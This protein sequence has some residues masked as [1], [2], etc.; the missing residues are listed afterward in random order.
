MMRDS[1]IL[2]ALGGQHCFY[3]RLEGDVRV[4]WCVSL[5]SYCAAIISQPEVE[6]VCVDIT[7]ASNLDS[8]TLGV[9]ARV[10]VQSAKHCARPALLLCDDDDIHRLISSMGFP[11]VYDIRRQSLSEE[12]SFDELPLLD[13]SESDLQDAVIAAHRALMDLSED[14]RAAFEHLV[15]VLERNKE[16]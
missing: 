12:V 16:K 11:S 10:A 8:T 15:D 4:P 7:A 6:A 5:E 13:S 9:L 2:V 3:L 1:K 14:N